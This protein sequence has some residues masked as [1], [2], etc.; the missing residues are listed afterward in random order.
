MTKKDEPTR[1]ADPSLPKG[2]GADTPKKS[3]PPSPKATQ[4]DPQKKT[5]QKTEKNAAP[6]KKAEKPSPR[7]KISFR[8]VLVYCVVFLLIGLSGAVYFLVAERQRMLLQI[9]D[10][11]AQLDSQLKGLQSRLQKPRPSP[12]L[13]ALKNDLNTFQSRVTKT[14]QIQQN[15]IHELKNAVEQLSASSPAREAREEKTVAE[16]E[17]AEAVESG[18]EH[19]EP[20][21]EKPEPV[22]PPHHE[23]EKEPEHA[24]E[25]AQEP[26]GEVAPARSADE[27]ETPHEVAPVQEEVQEHLEPVEEHETAAEEP[28]VVAIEEHAA[29]SAVEEHEAVASAPSE[30]AARPLHEPREEPG[31][32][33]K[34]SKEA[35]QYIDF[36]ETAAAKIF[37]LIKAGFRAAW[38]YLTHPAE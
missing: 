17:S 26:H 13:A 37:Q 34:R 27:P 30:E 18:E 35:Q 22:A 14:F 36:V 38:D 21:E 7:S 10:R 12:D 23:A 5:A 3:D 32:T 16:E 25:H 33:V 8:K 15:T 2:K 24:E 28:G 19:A 20:V 9:E 31:E 1:P 11:I 4:P 6:K 29:A